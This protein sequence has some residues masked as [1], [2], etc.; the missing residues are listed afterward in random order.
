MIAYEIV[1]SIDEEKQ[2]TG[3]FLWTIIEGIGALC[4]DKKVISGSLVINGLPKYNGYDLYMTFTWMFMTQA[5][6]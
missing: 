2:E 3:I 1:Y 4:S 5:S 6:G